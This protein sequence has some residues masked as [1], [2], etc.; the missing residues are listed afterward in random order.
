MREFKFHVKLLFF[1]TAITVMSAASGQKIGKITFE[2]KMLPSLPA[3][4]TAVVNFLNSF[5]ELKGVPFHVAEWFYWTNFSRHS[6]RAFWDSVVAP[7]IQTYPQLKTD[8]S[9]SLRK[10][11][12]KSNR[13]PMF[14]PN[15]QLM[16]T[17]QAHSADISRLGKL[18]HSS[19]A[20][21]PFE[22]RVFKVGIQKCAAENLAMGLPN[23]VFSLVLLYLDEGVQD[24]GHRK[25]LLNP[26]YVE[27]GIGISSFQK[28]YVMA[29]QDFA[30]D[31]SGN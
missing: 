12:Q 10:E 28:R 16:K 21:A 5:P 25:N 7:L 6:P 1:G 3:R 30:C 29:V 22:Q 13:L 24:L 9:E 2:E 31:Q 20:G 17:A 19:S 27:M 11:L 8:N 14:R 26:Y 4:N 18:S 23:P 15:Q